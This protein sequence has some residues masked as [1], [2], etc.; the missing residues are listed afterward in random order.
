MEETFQF[1]FSHGADNFQLKGKKLIAS[2][3]TGAPKEAYNADAFVGYEVEDFLA[4]I[5]VTAKMAERAQEHGRKV[6]ELVKTKL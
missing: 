5:K 4:P 6:V 2:V 3:T 1:G